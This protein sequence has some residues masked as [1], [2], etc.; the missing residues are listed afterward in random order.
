MALSVFVW[1]PAKDAS[2]LMSGCQDDVCSN[3]AARINP[4]H[5]RSLC[6]P[7]QEFVASLPR[8]TSSCIRSYRT[9]S[10][11]HMLVH[12]LNTL[13]SLGLVYP[14]FLSIYFNIQTCPEMN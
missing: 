10:S 12:N 2:V 11:S 13:A 6:H 9:I 1:K 14:H 8:W 5:H 7:V 4:D 3:E